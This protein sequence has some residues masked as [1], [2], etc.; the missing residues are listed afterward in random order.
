MNRA[1]CADGLHETMHQKRPYRLFQLPRHV[2]RH[3]YTRQSV[4]AQRDFCEPTSSH[5]H[6]RILGR[7]SPS[8]TIAGGGSDRGHTLSQRVLLIECQEPTAKILLIQRGMDDEDASQEVA[9]T[10]LIGDAGPGRYDL[11]VEARLIHTG[12]SPQPAYHTPAA[13]CG[14]TSRSGCAETRATPR[15]WTL[16][17]ETATNPG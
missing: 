14:R 9:V 5:K 13:C 12:S 3:A 6:R 16:D 4:A 10:S 17:L 1:A 8:R 15:Y 2:A 11:R 7:P